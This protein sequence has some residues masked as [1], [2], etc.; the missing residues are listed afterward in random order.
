M[1]TLFLT[2]LFILISSILTAQTPKEQIMENT[3]YLTEMLV[4]NEFYYPPVNEEMHT[5]NMEIDSIPNNDFMYSFRS[6]V[7]S[8]SLEGLLDNLTDNVFSFF[9]FFGGFQC[10]LPENQDFEYMYATFYAFGSSF[11]Y[12]IIEN[13]ENLTLV[14]ENSGN[15]ATYSNQLMAVNDLYSKNISIYPNPVK[16]ILIIDKLLQQKPSRVIIT[17]TS[18]KLVFQQKISNSKTEVNMTSLPSGIYFV[19]VE[20]N[21]KIFKT[22]KIVKK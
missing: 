9:D 14:V 12:T 13:S 11:D 1:K 17:D 18:S 6:E 20:E 21:G 5:I 8:S 19:S 2:I 7:C 4:D 22:E 16:D 10:T 15:S 3:W